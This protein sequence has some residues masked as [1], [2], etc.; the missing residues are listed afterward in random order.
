[1][2]ASPEEGPDGPVEAKLVEE[3]FTNDALL[4][5]LLVGGRSIRT[6]GEHPFY[7][8]GKGWLKATAL[9]KGDLLR[10][11]DGQWVPVEGVERPASTRRS[12]TCAWLTGTPTS[13]APGVGLQRLAH[14]E[15][16]SSGW[17]EGAR[18]ILGW[19]NQTHNSLL[20][21]GWRA[22][23]NGVDAFKRWATNKMT[24]AQA[25]ALIGWASRNITEEVAQQKPRRLLRLLS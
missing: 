23:K 11:D 5:E 12:T 14:N 9:Q 13:S 1:M 4:V 25:D 7:V 22:L 15:Y 24:G 17:T 10:S 3:V 16:F 19:V 6:T 21:N 18:Q 8:R 20:T 2:L